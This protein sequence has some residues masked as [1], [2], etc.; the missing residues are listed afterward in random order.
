MVYNNDTLFVKSACLYPW[1]AQICIDDEGLHFACRH[2]EHTM[3]YTC[4]YVYR[5]LRCLSTR[6]SY[7]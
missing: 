7:P 4:M 1:H 2:L 6:M 3:L 5:E